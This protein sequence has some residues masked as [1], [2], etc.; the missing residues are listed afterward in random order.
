MNKYVSNTEKFTR[1]RKGNILEVKVKS[2]ITKQPFAYSKKFTNR[3][4]ED[5]RKEYLETVLNQI[6]L[7]ANWVE[8]NF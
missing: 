5:E 3:P 2:I 6:G 7:T 1:L 4:T 8:S